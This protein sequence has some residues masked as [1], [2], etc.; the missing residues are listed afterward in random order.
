MDNV[1]TVRLQMQSDDEG[2][3]GYISY[4]NDCMTTPSQDD[5]VTS[6][7]RTHTDVFMRSCM[8]ECTCI[9]TRYTSMQVVW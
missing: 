3:L 4:G 7:V 2:Q 8:L 9:Y 1:E 6:G 5:E